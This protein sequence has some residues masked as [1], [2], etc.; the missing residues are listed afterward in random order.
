MRAAA[1]DIGIGTA[2]TLPPFYIQH[3][4]KDKDV[5]IRQSLDLYDK[6][7]ATGLL[8]DDDLV[9]DIIEGTRHAGAGPHYIEVQNVKPILEFY[10]RHMTN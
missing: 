4:D 9:L 7:K 5:P 10:K 8:D 1:A 6:L 3:G 2:R